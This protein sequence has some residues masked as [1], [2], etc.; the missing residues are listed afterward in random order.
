MVCHAHACPPCLAQ[1]T[2]SGSSG[3]AAHW[4]SPNFIATA[5]QWDV[6]T[7]LSHTSVLHYR[8]YV[9]RLAEE[10][11]QRDFTFPDGDEHDLVRAV[12]QRGNSNSAQGSGVGGTSLPENG[13]S[14]DDV[15]MRDA[16]SSS[17]MGQSSLY[18]GMND[19]SYPGVSA[20][21]PSNT[22]GA[23][24]GD[25]SATGIPPGT[26]AANG[27]A[28]PQPSPAEYRLAVWKTLQTL[29]KASDLS[30]EAILYPP[31][32][33]VLFLPAVNVDRRLEGAPNPK[34]DYVWQPSTWFDDIVLTQ[35]MIRVH[36]PDRYVEAFAARRGG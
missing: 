29:K 19:P 5:L 11:I 10:D 26:T 20:T 31:G 28:P 7:R 30:E 22:V 6:V 14:D 18:P 21:A 8:C 27:N 17:R 35:S 32:G 9:Q 23:A 13:Y 3:G 36:L 33:F 2:S 16:P 4:N 1:G 15:L 24:A 25:H 12:S 34:P